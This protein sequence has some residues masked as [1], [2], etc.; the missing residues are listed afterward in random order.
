MHQMAVALTKLLAPM[1][2]FT[3]D[4][5]WEHLPH[6]AADEAG[7]SSVHLALLPK[8]SGIQITP[9]QQEDWSLLMAL[10][11]DLLG[12]L[13]VLTRQIGKYKA[14]DA[15]VVYETSNPELRRKLEAFGVDLED[16][17]SAGHH[18]WSDAS[19][20]EIPALGV[21]VKL[22]DTRDLPGYASCARCWKR[23]PD[24]GSDPQ[25]P[26]LCRRCAA[27]V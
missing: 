16:I 17:V 14:L 4:E 2:V 10:R 19:G 13:D 15:E 8:L 12:Q 27:A 25:N 20:G 9:Q 24:V 6:K 11:N 18:R 5:V 7:L 1:L 21:R 22:V 3:A 23:R 26:D